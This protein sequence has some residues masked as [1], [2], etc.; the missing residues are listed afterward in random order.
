M[1]NDPII[2]SGVPGHLPQSSAL[3][4][5]VAPDLSSLPASVVA[6]LQEANDILRRQQQGQG[7]PM[8]LAGAAE[9]AK[10]SPEV[11]AM[12]AGAQIGLPSLSFEHQSV[13]STVVTN[14]SYV[15][16]VRVARSVQTTV[17]S[18]AGRRTGRL[19]P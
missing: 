18:S 19:G 3:P 10:S 14:E 12:I 15:L 4:S 13:D 9:L 2:H 1:N 7:M 11:F 8:L 6:H 5:Q 17:N 16:G